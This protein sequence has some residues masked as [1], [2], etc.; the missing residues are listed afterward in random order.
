MNGGIFSDV[1]RGGFFFLGAAFS[2]NDAIAIFRRLGKGNIMS[3]IFYRANLS[4]Y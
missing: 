4:R 1:E 2:L 3:L